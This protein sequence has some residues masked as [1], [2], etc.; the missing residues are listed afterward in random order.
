MTKTPR[1]TTLRP[2]VAMASQRLTPRPKTV[3]PYYSTPEHRA[4]RKA[5]YQRAGWRCEAILENGQR[6]EAS[7][8]RGDR[9]FADHVVERRDGGADQGEGKALCG[10]HHASKTSDERNK[11]MARREG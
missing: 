9:L 2:R 10:S 5:V 4:W 6:C 3:D 8:L 7:A 11:R 1:L